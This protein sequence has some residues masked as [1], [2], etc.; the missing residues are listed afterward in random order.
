MPEL[1]EVETVRRVIERALL[2]KRIAVADVVPDEIVLEG[3]PAEV[4]QAAVVGSTVKRVGRRGKY[5]WLEFDRTPWLF[6]HLGM[7]GWVRDVT[8]A[9]HDRHRVE[10]RLRE[11]GAAPLDDESGRPRFLKI[12]LESESGDRIAMTDGRRLSRLWLAD[13]ADEGVK[14][15]GPDMLDQPWS[16]GPLADRLR[17]RS[18]PIKAL[19]LDQRLFA[20]VGNWIADEVL[21]QAKIAPQRPA[22]SLS[23]KELKTLIGK[24]AGILETSVN[25]DADASKYPSDWLFNHRWGGAKGV[26]HIHGRPIVREQVGGRT[27]AWVPSVQK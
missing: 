6:G 4:V 15:L 23:P 8:P 5:W 22:G 25:V 18:A 27:T 16:A 24:L 3:V 21:Y 26:E 7:A 9:G 19:L 2:G 20:G 11:H 1:P 12:L 13:S 14:G 10:T 17:G